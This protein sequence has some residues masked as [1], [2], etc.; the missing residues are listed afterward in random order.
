MHMTSEEIFDKTEQQDPEQKSN[1]VGPQ[2][3]VRSKYNM[4]YNERKNNLKY[5]QYLK[6]KLDNVNQK[7]KQLN[8]KIKSSWN[9]MKAYEDMETFS[10]KYEQQDPGG[11]GR[12]A[13]SA[14]N[15]AKYET[16]SVNMS[17][18]RTKLTEL[19]NT[20]IKIP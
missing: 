7:I 13:A 12:G 6:A 4:L 1:I 9:S 15:G 19:R 5:K 11:T 2:V 3:P 17:L 8:L 20:L 10:R 16:D 18:Q 14:L